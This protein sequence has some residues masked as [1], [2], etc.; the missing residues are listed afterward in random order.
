MTTLDDLSSTVE[1]L[2]PWLGRRQP[3][4]AIILGSGLSE[5]SERLD[6]AISIPYHA[7]P[8]FPPPGV[9]G[10]AGQLHCGFIAG[11]PALVFAGRYH[12]YEGYSA[13]QVTAPV[14]LAQ[15]LGCRK[16]LL[17]NAVGGIT[18]QLRPGDFML[19]TD[20]LNLTGTNPLI[21]RSEADFID[22]SDL[23][24][25]GFFGQLRQRA[26]EKD[27]DLHSGVLAWMTGPNYETP[28]EIRALRQLG[29]DAVSMSTVPEAIVAR[30]LKL[31]TAALSYVANHA[32]GCRP[33]KL[34]HLDVLAAGRQAAPRLAILL[35]MLLPLWK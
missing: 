18:E 6:A 17:T 12:V 21:G 34:D 2:R 30:L 9:A 10:H 1:Q 25:S 22:L 26:A 31:E 3:E 20:H 8:G 24:L 29:A 19:V 23:Y 32:A 7:L 35:S 15:A 33:G 13:W 5:L 16:L 27:I 11:Q 14:R 4:L 28:A